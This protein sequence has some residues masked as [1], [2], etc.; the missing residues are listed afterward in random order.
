MYAVG[1]YAIGSNSAAVTT[2]RVVEMRTMVAGVAVLGGGGGVRK[3]AKWE[4]RKN[5]VAMM[6]QCLARVSSPLEL[7]SAL[8][9]APPARASE[10]V[11]DR[12][13]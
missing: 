9:A 2:R 1:D 6:E 12:C 3:I 11:A 10:Y 4:M 8:G 5:E 7:R 13:Q